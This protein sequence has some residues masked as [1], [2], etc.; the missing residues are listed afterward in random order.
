MASSDQADIISV[1]VRFL[2]GTDETFELTGQSSIRKLKSMICVRLGYPIPA[3]RLLLDGMVPDH[4]NCTFAELEISSGAVLSLIILQ[5]KL[6]S[7]LTDAEMPIG[8]V[9]RNP[10]LNLA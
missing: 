9:V 5:P 3:Q 8:T 10:T 2:S 1:A 7:E 6:G 4:D